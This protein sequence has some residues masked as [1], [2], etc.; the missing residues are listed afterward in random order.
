MKQYFSPGLFQTEFFHVHSSA[1]I[2]CVCVVGGMVMAFVCLVLA[3]AGG[4]RHECS[5]DGNVFLQVNCVTW[6]GIFHPCFPYPHPV[7]V[8]ILNK[9]LTG[10]RQVGK[11]VKN[12]LK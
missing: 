4:K 3:F 6:P 5:H 2:V 1:K 12:S 8:C 10:N 9:N 11:S 7:S